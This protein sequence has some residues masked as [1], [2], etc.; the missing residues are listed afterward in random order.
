MKAAV[1]HGPGKISYDTVDDPKLQ[2]DR[3][4]ITHRLP[5]SQI[6]DGYS[7]FK[8]KEDNCGKVVLHP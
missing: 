8:K 7:K 6:A 1:I 4:I 3:D 5:L 2:T